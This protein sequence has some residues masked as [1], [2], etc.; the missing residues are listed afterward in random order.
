MEPSPIFDTP[1][2]AS[3]E[4]FFFFNFKVSFWGKGSTNLHPTGY[5]MEGGVGKLLLSAGSRVISKKTE[6]LGR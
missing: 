2:C 3:E 1:A 4:F 5:W 6:E